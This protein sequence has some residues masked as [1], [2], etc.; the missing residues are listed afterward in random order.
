[1]GVAVGNMIERFV[2]KEY[3]IKPCKK[4]MCCFHSS[5]HPFCLFKPAFFQSV[6]SLLGFVYC[7]SIVD[8]LHKL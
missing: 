7:V 5:Q 6:H 2:N 1:M 8:A 3:L 4:A